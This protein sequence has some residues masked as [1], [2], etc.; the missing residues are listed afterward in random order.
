M[1]DALLKE[2]RTLERGWKEASH[3]RRLNWN[4]QLRLEDRMRRVLRRRQAQIVRSGKHVITLTEMKLPGTTKAGQSRIR[5][6]MHCSCGIEPTTS[7]VG[8]GAWW[9]VEED[10]NRHTLRLAAQS[11]KPKV[12]KGVF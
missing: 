11:L 3:R 5:Y 4:I 6:A 2:M 10:F 7:P 9:I 1:A 8:K 12:F